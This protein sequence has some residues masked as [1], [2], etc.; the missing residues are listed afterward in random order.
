MPRH[1]IVMVYNSVAVHVAAKILPGISYEDIL[2]CYCLLRN[3]I[4][5]VL[6]G[7]RQ[8]MCAG[9]KHKPFKNRHT[10]LGRA[11]YSSYYVAYRVA[12]IIHRKHQSVS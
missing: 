10:A 1:N 7:E 5:G 6:P 12:V 3:K 11:P 2:Y 9:R 8:L 4:I